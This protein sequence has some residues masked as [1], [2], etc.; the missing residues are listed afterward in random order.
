MGWWKTA[1]SVASVRRRPK[2]R[3]GGTCRLTHLESQGREAFRHDPYTSP[4]DGTPTEWKGDVHR[5]VQEHAAAYAVCVWREPLRASRGGQRHVAC[6]V[7]VCRPLLR[8]ANASTCFAV[9]L[10]EGGLECPTTRHSH[11]PNVPQLE[12]QGSGGGDA[13]AG[14]R[15][16][17]PESSFPC[18]PGLW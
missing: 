15:H 5:D 12:G 14:S 8:S 13:R 4:K 3:V 6:V 10:E 9:L 17:S 11:P 16:V 18:C 7:E 1:T 2:R